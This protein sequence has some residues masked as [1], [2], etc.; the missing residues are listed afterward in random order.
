ML[1]AE[2]RD[3]RRTD[4]CERAPDEVVPAS[5]VFGV[6]R[7][8]DDGD[9]GLGHDGVVGQP[10]LPPLPDKAGFPDLVHV[11]RQR[12]RHYVARQAI[13]YCPRLIRRAHPS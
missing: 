11:Q 12:Q 5:D 13:A 4:K 3:K 2:R 9:H 6:A 7:P 1:T 8:R 10:L